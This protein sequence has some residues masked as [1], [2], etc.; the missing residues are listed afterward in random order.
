MPNDVHGIRIRAWWLLLVGKRTVRAFV[1]DSG[2][3]WSSSIAFYL[4]LSVPPLLIAFTS[5][6]LAIVGQ[7]TRPIVVE[8][9]SEFLPAGSSQLKAVVES[10]VTGFGPAAALSVA[11]LLVSGTRVFAAMASAIDSFWEHVDDSGWL[12][13]QVSRLLLLVLVGG[14]FT[15]SVGIEIAAAV[16][17]EDAE[18]SPVVGWVLRSQVLPAVL[19]FTGLFAT[20]LLLPRRAAR[21]PTAAIG[22]LVGTILLRV[23]QGLFALFIR[24]VADFESAYGPMATIAILMTWALIASGAVLLAAELVAVLDRHTDRGRQRAAANRQP[25]EESGAGT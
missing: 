7:E 22:A 21:W 17:G 14:L 19:V 8:R 5:I 13:R 24:T 12:Q 16:I 6:G 4:V 20:F 9:I 3:M 25:D 2:L 1:D 15:A 23:A 11:F 18:L 10:N